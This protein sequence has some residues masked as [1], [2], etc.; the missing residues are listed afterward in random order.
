MMGSWWPLACLSVC[1]CCTRI[2]RHS[3]DS[4]SSRCFPSRALLWLPLPPSTHPWVHTFNPPP[5]TTT[6][7]HPFPIPYFSTQSISSSPPSP[8]SSS[9]TGTRDHTTTPPL[10]NPPRILR[11]VGRDSRPGPAAPDWYPCHPS[12]SSVVGPSCPT[13]SRVVPAVRHTY[14][15]LFY[16]WPLC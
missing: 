3:L 5:T 2:K 14:N 1:V 16:H 11:T 8:H 9:F 12:S 10:C 7:H 15:T 13:M 6:H 4:L